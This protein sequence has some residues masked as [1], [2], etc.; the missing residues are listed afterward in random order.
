MVDTHTHTH[1]H[2]YVGLW[3]G[4]GGIHTQKTP[5]AQEGLSTVAVQIAK[6][7]GAEECN[8]GQDGQHQ[9]VWHSTKLKKTKGPRARIGKTPGGSHL[10]DCKVFLEQN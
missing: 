1:T 2:I 3:F 7:A 5:M 6:R 4:R 9:S 8:H 10:S